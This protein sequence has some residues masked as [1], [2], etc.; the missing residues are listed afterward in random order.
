M[1]Y[2]LKF[3]ISNFAVAVYDTA[4]LLCVYL[5]RFSNINSKFNEIKKNYN[6][7]DSY[8]RIFFPKFK[9]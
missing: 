5:S 2:E 8:L 3:S 1:Y 9:I 4:R 6:L 7:Q